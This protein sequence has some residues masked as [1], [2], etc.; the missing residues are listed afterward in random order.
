MTMGHTNGSP[1]SGHDSIHTR[2]NSAGESAIHEKHS[3]RTR[4]RMRIRRQDGPNMPAYWEEFEIPYQPGHNVLSVLMEFRKNPVNIEGKRVEPIVWESNC[5]EQVC[6]ACSMVINGRARQGCTA[7]VDDLEDPITIEPMDKFPIIRDLAVDRSR[8]FDN[9]KRVKAWIEIDGSHDLG[10]AP[11][12]DPALAAER[13]K[14][15][16]CMSCGVCLQVCPQVSVNNNF[17]GAAILSQVKLFNIHPTG[18]FNAD[19]RLDAIMGDGGVEDCGNAQNCVKACPKTIP[20]TESIA[21]I[22]RQTTGRA[23]RKFLGV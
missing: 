6:G 19:E 8:M 13:Y 14:L 11:R 9:L 15:S 4:I 16:T 22:G 20:L 7:L 21:D 17:V 3:R 12:M 23:I 18:K 2:S 5:L 10:P 1:A